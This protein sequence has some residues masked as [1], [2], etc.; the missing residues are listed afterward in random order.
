MFCDFEPD[1]PVFIPFLLRNV[2]SRV[3]SAPAL[4]T[5]QASGGFGGPKS[6]RVSIAHFPLAAP[7]AEALE[8]ESC[9]GTAGQDVFPV[10][11]KST[12]WCGGAVCSGS[13]GF[14][15]SCGI[16]DV[17]ERGEGYFAS[18]SFSSLVSVALAELGY[19]GELCRVQLSVGGMRLDADFR[20]GARPQTTVFDAFAAEAFFPPSLEEVVVEDVAPAKVGAPAD[21]PGSM[22]L[23]YVVSL[24]ETI[25][26]PAYVEAAK[27]DAVS[28]VPVSLPPPADG[29][30]LGVDPGPAIP[31]VVNALF[32]CAEGVAQST[33]GPVFAGDCDGEID[34]RLAVLQAGGT[35]PRGCY[36]IVGDHNW[37]NILR[38]LARWFASSGVSVR[39]A[40][41]DLLLGGLS[42]ARDDR[43]R[44]LR[45]LRFL[46][47]G[48]GGDEAGVGD[49]VLFPPCARA[50]VDARLAYLVWD[51]IGGSSA[52]D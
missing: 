17:D 24:A 47:L 14:D 40:R 34:A 33:P 46:G 29:P 5:A 25:L 16:S 37:F 45:L 49:R 10:G 38:G 12:V 11:V 44:A 8:E 27:A 36:S 19:L 20:G 35:L 31:C 22:P 48:R 1:F 9:S 52:A 6:V 39:G 26:P 18:T 15:G 43:L 41:M 51:W 21:I 2:E 4:L 32:D 50:V 28:L 42:V 30:V 23:D 13:C 7:D 3:F